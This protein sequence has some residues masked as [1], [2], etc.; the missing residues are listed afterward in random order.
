MMR[1]GWLVLLIILFSCA[2][3]GNTVTA[4]EANGVRIVH[5]RTMCF[6][7]CPAFE[8]IWNGNGSAFLKISK[9]FPDDEG[10]R[11]SPG[12][13]FR[14]ASAEN[15]KA[16]KD[17]LALSHSLNF[18]ELGGTYD[19]P[20]IM[21]LPTIRTT[22]DG[23]EVVDRFEGP[24]LVLLYDAIETWIRTGKWTHKPTENQ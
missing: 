16:L 17:I 10:E 22:I 15:L 1:A 21:D 11:L 23:V 4:T 9:G 5:E 12:H 19:N 6:G 18:A 20:M 2:Q 3:R 13:Y 24:D 14:D 7:P 8:L